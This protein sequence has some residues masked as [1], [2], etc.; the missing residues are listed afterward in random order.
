MGDEPV[1]KHCFLSRSG[2]VLDRIMTYSGFHRVEQAMNI[3]EK[4]KSLLQMIT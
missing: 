1:M 2:I 3:V 4:T